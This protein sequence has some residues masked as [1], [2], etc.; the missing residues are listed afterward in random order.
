[1]TY[2]Y[3]SNAEIDYF[4]DKGMGVIRVP[5]LW[6]RL[7]SKQG[8]ALDGAEL[9]RLD[10]V[11]QKAASRG[12]QVVLDMH[13]YGQG[14]GND[15]GSAGTPNA[16]FADVWGRIA[17]HYKGSGNVLFGLMNEPH[18]QSAQQW[19]GSANAA[20]AAIRASGARQEILVPGSYWDGAHSWVST[21]NDTVIGTGVVDPLHN[22]AFEV[23]QYLDADSSGTQPGAVSATIG[24]ERLTAIT[25][26][27]EATGNRLFLGEFG[28]GSDAQSLQALSGMVG[29]MAAHPVWQGA[30]Y[31]AAGAWWGD[32]AFSI[33]PTGLGTAH[34]KDR[35]QMDVLEH[36][37][38]PAASVGPDTTAPV[39]AIQGVSGA[40]NVVGGHVQSG[41]ID[42]ADA[43]SSVTIRDGR[44]TLG[45][46]QADAQ[47]HFT[48][49]LDGASVGAGHA[50]ALTATARDAAGNVG[51]S[52]SFQF[53]LDY[54]PNRSLFGTVGHDVHSVT[55]QVYA[56]YEGLL[57]R[58]PDAVGAEG[59][60]AEL[61]AGVSVHNLTQG[62]LNSAEGQARF[63]ASDNAGFVR[64]LYGAM[65]GGH[66]DAGAMQGLVHQLDA[67]VSRADVAHSF[68]FSN[69]FVAQLQPALNAGVFV[70]DATASAVAHLYYGLLDRAPDAGGLLNATA[71]VQGG[72]S[73][74]GLAQSIL[75]STEYA[76]RHTGS[77]TDQH[78]VEDLYANALGRAPEAAGEQ[79]W[80]SALAHGGTRAQVAVGIAESLEADQHLLDQVQTGWHLT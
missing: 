68:V 57:G 50:Y 2:T 75:T 26:W 54:T 59:L 52:D 78:Y 13:D 73:L 42:P 38:V 36:Y 1:M 62:F 40:G 17:Q 55:G 34:V 46:V 15:V 20:I 19:L 49:A 37:L 64:Q 58:A 5:F 30:T 69:E 33:E 41:T 76:G 60:A 74:T 79:H 51:T 24:V 7:Q 6:E 11:V 4:A 56:L 61:N 23:H 67:G 70:A 39:L 72:L 18:N 48:L 3:P 45:T 25:Q 21:D 16:S 35:A 9:S 29:Y 63:T 8:G 31:W 47:G 80:L 12:L 66:G 28:A 14:F 65:P 22:F 10:A 27:A 43:G 77:V 32:Y 44:T 71:A 53:V